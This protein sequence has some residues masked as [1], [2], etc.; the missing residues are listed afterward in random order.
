MTTND[1]DDLWAVQFLGLEYVTFICILF[2]MDYKVSS[3]LKCI[4]MYYVY[5]R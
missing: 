5:I 2:Y 4:L 3:K 1:K